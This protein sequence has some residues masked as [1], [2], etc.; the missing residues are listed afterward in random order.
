[1]FD[2][3]VFLNMTRSI[4]SL[5]PVCANM[6]RT[7]LA[8]MRPAPVPEGEAHVV[9]RFQHHP[10]PF[11]ISGSSPH[12]RGTG[13][14]AS[15]RSVTGGFIPARTGNSAQHPAEA[16]TCAVHPRTYR[17]QTSQNSL[18]GNDI[19]DVPGS[20]G[21]SDPSRSL[22]PGGK[23]YQLQ[24]V[25]IDGQAVAA[26]RKEIGTL[27]LGNTRRYR[28]RDHDPLGSA[29][30]RT[31]PVCPIRRAGRI[32]GRKQRHHLIGAGVCDKSHRDGV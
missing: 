23:G 21:I 31:V 19:H 4:C 29:D 32:T 14:T 7:C 9:R 8:E 15:N 25:E 27:S 30:A 6:K 24:P 13:A 16:G 20:T 22:F 26:R 11:P 1:M 12:V 3:S 18:S 5:R 10:A 17:E 2:K 28:G